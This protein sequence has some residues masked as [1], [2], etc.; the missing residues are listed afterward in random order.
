MLAV[1][2][3]AIILAMQVA[4]WSVGITLAII[5]APIPNSRVGEGA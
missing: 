2:I 3:A 5:V 1:S 4:A